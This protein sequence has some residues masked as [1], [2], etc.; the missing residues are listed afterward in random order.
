[1]HLS[2][3]HQFHEVVRVRFADA[4]EERV[5]AGIA[6]DHQD[7]PRGRVGVVHDRRR[8]RQPVAELRVDDQRGVDAVGEVGDTGVDPVFRGTV[9]V[10]AVAVAEVRAAVPVRL[11]ERRVALPPAEFV[12]EHDLPGRRGEQVVVVQRRGEELLQLVGGQV[13]PAAPGVR[14]LVAGV[15]AGDGSPVLGREVVDEDRGVAGRLL[16]VA[17]RD[18]GR[19]EHVRPDV[20]VVNA[21]GELIR[22]QVVDVRVGVKG[23]Q[24]GLQVLGQVRGGLIAV[25]DLAIVPPST[26]TAASP[27][28]GVVDG[29][30]RVGAQGRR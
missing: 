18:P 6:L 23:L 16:G 19:F 10:V 15:D 14:G 9:A 24:R 21:G 17:T 22:R 13:P 12:L 27:A 29:V 2:V 26:C 5:V 25:Q 7:R 4:Q 1:M 28:W 11:P 30:V 20:V 8:G 3:H